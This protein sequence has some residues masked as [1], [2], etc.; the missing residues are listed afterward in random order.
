[1]ALALA[2]LGR[3]DEARANCLQARNTA[4]ALEGL[5]KDAS[6]ALQLKDQAMVSYLEGDL[7]QAKS[8]LTVA[9]QQLHRLQGADTPAALEADS[10]LAEIDARQGRAPNAVTL[11]RA[12]YTGLREREGEDSSDTAM[13][14]LRLGIVLWLQGQPSA[15]LVEA[16]EAF[17]TFEALI[18]PKAPDT[19]FARAV[20][21][22]AMLA[23]GDRDAVTLHQSIDAT[24]MRL[25]VPDDRWR[26]TLLT[27]SGVPNR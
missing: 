23:K 18:G 22:Q 21:A 17:Q 5:E 3:F 6:I 25:S 8:A 16:R 15:A 19:Q 2:H 4:L 10:V 14:R 1:L 20:V 11:A 13:A 12:A 7:V 26:E 9:A 27:F 24:A